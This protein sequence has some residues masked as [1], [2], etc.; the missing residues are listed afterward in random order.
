MTDSKPPSTILSS[1]WDSVLRSFVV[2]AG[3]Q[4]NLFTPLKDGPLSAS[5]IADAIGVDVIK[6][7]PLLYA[8]VVVGLLTVED[9]LFANTE[10][11]DHHLV[12]DRPDYAGIHGFL[13]NDLCSA[14]LRT[15]DSIRTGI[16]QAE[17]DY[18]SLS[19]DYLN[20]FF[21]T[22]HPGSV[23]VGQMFAKEYDFSSCRS[24]IDVGG[25]SGGVAIAMAEA[26]PQLRATVVELPSVTPFTRRYVDRSADRGQ[27]PVSVETN[28][29]L[30]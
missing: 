16:P 4:L 27:G 26:Y 20:S 15:A 14:A 1:V 23:D 12:K 24:L 5:E 6:L 13:M 28:H 2:L 25:G 19:A 11:A 3:M 21:D 7:R 8:L 29:R 30:G 18:A 9:E 22:R 17:R 10:E